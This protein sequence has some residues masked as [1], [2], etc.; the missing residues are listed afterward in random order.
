MAKWI[1]LNAEE[2]ALLD[3]QDSATGG[4][5]GFQSMLVR[6]QKDLRRGTSELKLADDDIERIGR[7]AF[8]M[9]NGGWQTRLVGIFGRSLGPRLGRASSD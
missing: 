3:E 5:G 9:G 2:I 4:D 1:V 6:F 7:Y 8:D